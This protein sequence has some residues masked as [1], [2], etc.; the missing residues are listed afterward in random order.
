MQKPK[1]QFTLP[2]AKSVTQP[3]EQKTTSLYDPFQINMATIRDVNYKYRET[4]IGTQRH[5]A[6][7]NQSLDSMLTLRRMRDERSQ[8]HKKRRGVTMDKVN[9]DIQKRIAAEREKREFSESEL[10]QT[11]NI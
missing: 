6:D 7:I 11:D 3:N 1:P 8:R 4:I 2:P 9:A 10:E 5:L